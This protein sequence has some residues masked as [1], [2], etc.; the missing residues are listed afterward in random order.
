MTKV[1]ILEAKTET[2]QAEAAEKEAAAATLQASLQAE[3]DEANETVLALQDR[4]DEL[5]PLEVN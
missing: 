4:V 1:A 5:E 3:F 2:L